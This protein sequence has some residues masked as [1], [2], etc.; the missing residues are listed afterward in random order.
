MKYLEFEKR[1]KVGLLTIQRPEVLN[2]LNYEALREIGKFLDTV[3]DINALI[4]TGSGDRAFMAG[5]DVKEMQNLDSTQIVQFSRYGQGIVRKLEE[6]PFIT[7]AAVNGYALGGGLELALGCDFIYA[8]EKAKL[9]LPEIKLGIIP[10]WGGTHRLSRAIGKRRA[11]ELMM[12]GRMISAEEAFA[13]GFVNRVCAPDQLLPDC[14]DVANEMLQYSAFALR[15]IK[16][17]VD[18]LEAGDELEAERFAE[19]FATDESKRDIEKFL[20]KK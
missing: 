13:M 18:V 1:D 2:T 7:L 5:A 11:K 14:W 6:V 4:L 8:S 20:A 16:Q 10:G 17:V 19:C 15:Q 3:D 9:G 12:T